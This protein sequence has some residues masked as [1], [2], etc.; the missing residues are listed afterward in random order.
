M[1]N[2]KIKIDLDNLTVMGHSFGGGK[3]IYIYLY[4]FIFK[5]LKIK[6]IKYN[7]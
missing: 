6:N 4:K 7:N 1:G 2:N 3:K 5:I